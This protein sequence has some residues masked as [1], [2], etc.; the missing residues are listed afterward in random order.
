MSETVYLMKHVREVFLDYCKG[1]AIHSKVV[2]LSSFECIFMIIILQTNVH[3][4]LK[5]KATPLNDSLSVNDNTFC[6]SFYCVK[7][8]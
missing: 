3:F 8:L 4:L 1:F 6:I 2:P 7:N 5:Y